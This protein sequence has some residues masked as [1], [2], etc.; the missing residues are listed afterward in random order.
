KSEAS[1]Y[2]DMNNRDLKQQDSALVKL[3]SDW[4]PVQSIDLEKAPVIIAGMFFDNKKEAGEQLHATIAQLKQKGVAT[5][6][7]IAR[8]LDFKLFYNPIQSKVYV[9]G[10]SGMIYNYADGKLNE[11]PALAG[12]YMTDSIKRIPKVIDNTKD[13]IRDFQKKITTYQNELSADF[14]EKSLINDLKHQIDQLSE[15]L[16]KAFSKEP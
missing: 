16:E 13:S 15:R 11:N 9:S 14:K 12:R 10:P 3:E 2:I 7:E 1:F 5:E 4:R 6:T 8:L